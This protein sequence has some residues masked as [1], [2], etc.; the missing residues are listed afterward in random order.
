M[1][2]TRSLAQMI[3]LMLIFLSLVACASPA[4][5]ATPV[6]PTPTPILPTA[7]PVPPTPTP[8][9]PTATPVPPTPTPILPTATPV[10]PTPT[11]LPPTPTS[12]GSEEVDEL[13]VTFERDNCIYNGPK[14]IRQ[15]EVTIIFNN[16]TDA[17]VSLVVSTLS[18]KFLHKKQRF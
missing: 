10:L 2:H 13:S 3:G 1:K 14:V 11:P 6:P 5:T 18:M 15:G 4:L 9:P 12:T 8:M 16:L 17:T 7:T